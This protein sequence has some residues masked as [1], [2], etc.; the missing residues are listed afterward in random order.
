MLFTVIN[1]IVCYLYIGFIFSVLMYVK[2]QTDS[3]S[4]VLC[5]SWK[6]DVVYTLLWP[7]IILIITLFGLYKLFL[8]G[9]T[10]L[11]L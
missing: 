10:L 6:D 7:V 9:K 5:W 3:I 1:Y 2:W 8:K 11:N 4:K